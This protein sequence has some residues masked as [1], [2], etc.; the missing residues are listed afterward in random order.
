[1]TLLEQLSRDFIGLDRVDPVFNDAGAQESRRR[2]YLDTTATA[3]MPRPVWQGLERYLE[4]ASANSHTEAHRAGRDTTRAIEDSRD[5]VGRLVGYQPERDVVIFA[6]NGATGAANFLARALFPSELRAVVKRFPE[7]APP[8]FVQAF[9]NH[10]GASVGAMLDELTARPLVVT[11]QMEH[12]S[13][14][15][16]WREA[17]GPHNIRVP[18][19]RERPEDV[20]HLARHFIDVH[21]AGRSVRLSRS[22]LRALAAYPWPGNVRQLENEI[23]R[24][25]VFADATILADHLS[26]EVLDSGKGEASRA[27]GLNVRRRVDALESELVRAALERTG[28]NQTRAAELLGLSRFGLQKMMKRLGINASTLHGEQGAVT[29]GG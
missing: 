2:V 27:D 1:M 15:L 4:A 14:L 22:A 11:T 28:G 21:A 16:P 26:L 8:E 24:A 17:V 25:L 12:H 19:L 10:L 13:N 9:K 5:A 7:G 29:D 18:P 23:R 20:E 3:L 6:S